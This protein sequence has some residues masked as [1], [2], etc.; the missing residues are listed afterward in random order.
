MTAGRIITE[1][2]L[3]NQEF[4]PVNIIPPQSSMLI[5]ITWGM[6]NTPVGGHSSETCS[7]SI[8]M[9]IIM[10]SHGGMILAGEN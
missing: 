10:E 5:Y 7:Y 2:W 4:S 3:T 6:N 9:I 1:L 8:D